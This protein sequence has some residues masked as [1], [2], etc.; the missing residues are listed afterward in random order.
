MGPKLEYFTLTLSHIKQK[1]IIFYTFSKTCTN[2]DAVQG[3]SHARLTSSLDNQSNIKIKNTLQVC[4]QHKIHIR[5]YF[6]SALQ[7]WNI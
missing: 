6:I 2:Q 7:I 4:N 5:T 3:S 1:I